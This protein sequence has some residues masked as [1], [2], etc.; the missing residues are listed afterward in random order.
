[1]MELKPEAQESTIFLTASEAYPALE[2]Q[3]L[4]ARSHI[5]AGFRVFDLRTK[6][7]SAQA[8]AIGATWY[9]LITH[10]LE[11][12]V[13]FRLILTDFD[14]VVRPASHRMTWRAMRRL[15]CAGEA[16]G[17]P[18]LLHVTVA[19][20]PARIGFGASVLLWPKTMREIAI[21]TKR[22][23]SL[24]TNAAKN[25]LS[26]M[27]LLA[28]HVTG[29]HPN[30][31]PNFRSLPR[32]VPTTHHQK[33]AVFDG[34]TAYIGGLDLDER[35]YDT[36]DHDRPAEDTWRDC[37]IMTS[38][39]VAQ[40]VETHLNEMLKCTA[41]RKPPSPL[42]QLLRTLSG[43]KNDASFGLSPQPLVTEIE[44][45]HLRCVASAKSLIYFETQ[46]FR[47][48]PLANALAKAAKANPD[49]HLLIVL[50]A[51]P[52]DV[53]FEGSKKSDARYGEYLQAK[54][55]DQVAQAFGDR[56]LAV[57]PAQP[58]TSKRDDRG[59]LKAA[60]LVYVHS[61]VSIFDDQTAIVSSAN[62]NGRSLRW[63]TEAGMMLTDQ[64]DVTALMSR[65][66]QHWLPDH[67]QPPLQK[68]VKLWRKRAHEN[69]QTPPEDRHGFILP[70]PIAPGRRF[71]R[72]LPGVPEEMT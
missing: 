9:D 42:P 61:K 28:Q 48:R 34:T 15:I 11:R 39:P 69:A 17:R 32:L 44:D 35:R 5:V 37:Q 64:K 66:F 67:D 7:R 24:D 21:E 63:D 26:A 30:F 58:K 25:D 68:T 31:R 72:N 57:A 16:S 29:A 18:D 6:L 13:S 50:P 62:L 2:R 46:F 41:G 55:L 23:N 49:L 1:M 36:P 53:A 22:L 45:A 27:P 65:C 14:P 3:F 52:E 60:P 12:G 70:Y 33:I 10:T 54:C 47:S 8:K 20:H 40:D 19:M 51:A 38:G 43:P 59:A 4:E 71:G 56:F